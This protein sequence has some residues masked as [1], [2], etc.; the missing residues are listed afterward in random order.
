MPSSSIVSSG[1]TLKA[2]EHSFTPLTL[3]RPAAISSSASRREAMPARASRLA[4][5]SLSAAP[6]SSDRRGPAGRTERVANGLLSRRGGRGELP[7][8]RASARARGAP[9]LSRRAGRWSAPERSGF[10]NGLSPSGRSRFTNVR[11]GRSPKLGR[12][13]SA[14][15]TKGFAPPPLKPPPGTRGLEITL[16]PLATSAARLVTAFCERLLA[17]RRIRLR[18]KARLALATLGEWPRARWPRTRFPER[19]SLSSS[20]MWRCLSGR[21]EP[22]TLKWN[23]FCFSGGEAIRQERRA[24]RCGSS[25]ERLDEP[26]VRRQETRRAG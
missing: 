19:L 16:W 24:G 8:P 13:P 25:A 20:A 10:L 3:T 21:I 1:M 17:A 4:M 26:G 5:R 18:A 23:Q 7:S 2:G 15:F 14:R 11:A 12:S 6:S 9:S 22:R